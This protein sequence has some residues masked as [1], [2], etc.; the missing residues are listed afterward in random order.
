MVNAGSG[1]GGTATTSTSTYSDVSFGQKAA[2][3]VGASGVLWASLVEFGVGVFLKAMAVGFVELVLTVSD[4]QVDL[5]VGFGEFLAAFVRLWTE[6]PT[7]AIA[8]AWDGAAFEMFGVF[9]PL[10]VLVEIL[11]VAAV[12]NWAVSNR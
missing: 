10:V 9:A 4:L 11:V 3:F 7:A 12:A 5:F 1:D 6:G 8:A 2:A